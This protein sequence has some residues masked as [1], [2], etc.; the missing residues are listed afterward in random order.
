MLYT[1]N[2]SVNTGIDFDS[3]DNTAKSARMH[4]T[5]DACIADFVAILDST[6]FTQDTL[7]E[8]I[9][10]FEYSR[11]LIDKELVSSLVSKLLDV[12]KKRYWRKGKDLE[13]FVD[14]EAIERAIYNNFE[15]SLLSKTPV[16][17]R[18][19]LPQRA[20]EA[21]RAKVLV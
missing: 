6:K 9:E 19:R 17:K 14:A 15:H 18:I 7:P 2:E 20:V 11:G 16:V 12:L 3:A 8:E 5:I 21:L 13:Q 4:D 10:V 1:L